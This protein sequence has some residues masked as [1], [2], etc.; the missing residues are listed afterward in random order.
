MNF[1]LDV[2]KWRCGGDYYEKGCGRGD[3]DTFLL[4]K[5]GNMCCLGQF[6]LQLGLTKADIELVPEPASASVDYGIFGKCSTDIPQLTKDL[7]DI[8]DNSETTITTKLK[9]IRSRLKRNGHTLEVK[10]APKDFV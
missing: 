3:T 9:K 6:G 4:D 10:N 7:I 5:K 8:N 2:K 1:I